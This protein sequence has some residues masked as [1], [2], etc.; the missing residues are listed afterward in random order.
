M[1]DTYTAG[2]EILVPFSFHSKKVLSDWI[3]RHK[4]PNII[5]KLIPCMDQIDWDIIVR[6]VVLEM[7]EHVYMAVGARKRQT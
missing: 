4:A 3:F 7:S 6:T 2:T 5:K 1:S